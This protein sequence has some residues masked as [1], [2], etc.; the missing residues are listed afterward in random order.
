M[1]S[2]REASTQLLESS[3]FSS[4]EMVA[5]AAL[6][7]FVSYTQRS[8]APLVSQ[9]SKFSPQTHMAIDSN[10]RRTLELTNPLMGA[11]KKATLFGVM[12]NTST[13][14]GQRLLYSRLCAPSAEV[15]VIQKRLDSVEFFYMNRPLAEELQ[16]TLKSCPDIERKMQ[17]VATRA[18]SL[19]DLRSIHSAIVLYKNIISLLYDTYFNGDLHTIDELLM[20]DFSLLDGLYKE[21]DTAVGQLV[22]DYSVMEGYSNT[23]DEISDKL[24]NN[25]REVDELKHLYRYLLVGHVFGGVH[26][27]M[28]RT[29]SKSCSYGK[30]SPPRLKAACALIG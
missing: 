20:K 10:T 30:A 3:Q 12:N 9:P 4:L 16:K 25:T 17:R 14:S 6:L 2:S 26:V 24:N 7:K 11:D 23:V 8:V 27:F 21:L 18:A 1:D 29:G 5:G 28:G 13:A 22:S 19:S 15:D